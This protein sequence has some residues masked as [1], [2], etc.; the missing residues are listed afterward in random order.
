MPSLA[1]INYFLYAVFPDFYVSLGEDFLQVFT[2]VAE[3]L[4]GL[5]YCKNFY[6]YCLT[7]P[8]IRSAAADL[9]RQAAGSGT[10]KKPETTIRID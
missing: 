1:N 6:L 9:V 10:A 7:N 5:K 4:F 8:D 2:S 3:I